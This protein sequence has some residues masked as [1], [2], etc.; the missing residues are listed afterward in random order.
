MAAICAWRIRRLFAGTLTVPCQQDGCNYQ[1]CEAP[2]EEASRAVYFNRQNF[3]PGRVGPVG[4]LFPVRGCPYEC[5]VA[6]GAP[7]GNRY[8]VSDFGYGLYDLY[9]A[10][11]LS[12]LRDCCGERRVDYQDARPDRFEQL[13]F[14]NGI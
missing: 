3:W 6:N 2:L 8:P 10:Q 14:A 12:Q 7:H 13:L 5:W 4:R 9:V 1:C 11:Y